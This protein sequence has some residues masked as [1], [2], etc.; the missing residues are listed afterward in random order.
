MKRGQKINL[1][2]LAEL[3]AWSVK[4][5][6]T[7]F[8]SEDLVRWSDYRVLDEHGLV[9]VND[10]GMFGPGYRINDSGREALRQAGREVNSSK[11]TPWKAQS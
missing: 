11:P 3:D 5:P 2:L 9:E 1:D 6:Y 7:G 10:G 4:H 8:K